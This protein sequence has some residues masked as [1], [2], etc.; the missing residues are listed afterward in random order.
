L[1]P[2]APREVRQLP[3]RVEQTLKLSADGATRIVGTETPTALPIWTVYGREGRRVGELPL[4][5]ATPLRLP[6]PEYRKLGPQ[7]FWSYV[8]RP[9]DAKPGQ[10]LPT[11]VY[12]YGGPF[13]VVRS[14]GAD[15]VKNQWLADQGFLVVAFDNRGTLRRDH[16]WERA[17]RKDPIGV[18]IGD[19]AAA[20]AARRPILDSL[21]HTG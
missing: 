15:L 5:R 4:T 6:T 20:G 11:V 9:K 1:P 19:Q 18:I 12:T 10:K 16:D 17:A 8:L 14:S 13:P 2:A 3:E 7:G 21:R